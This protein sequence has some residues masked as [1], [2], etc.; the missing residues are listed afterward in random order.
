MGKG[1]APVLAVCSTQREDAC[2]QAD[3]YRDK[4]AGLGTRAS[5][6]PQDLS[7]S[8]I[9]ARLGMPGAYTRSVEQFMSR[10][11]PVVATRLRHP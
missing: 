5:V 1:A 11:D 2:R 6:L 7:H 9:N 10:L 3:R 4:A 8:E